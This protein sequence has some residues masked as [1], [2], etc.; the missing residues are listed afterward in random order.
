VVCERRKLKKNIVDVEKNNN[1]ETL[2]FDVIYFVSQKNATPGL[3]LLQGGA[4]NGR[5]ETDHEYLFRQV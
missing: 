5:A 4:P 2:G 1:K 3:I